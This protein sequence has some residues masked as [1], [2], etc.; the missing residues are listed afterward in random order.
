MASSRY[1]T[2]SIMLHWLT[3]IV[4]AL[5]YALIELHHYFPKHTFWHDALKHWHSQLGLVV[6]IIT[7]VRLGV[8]W[9]STYS[10]SS[11]S[12][13]L[14]IFAADWQRQ[15][16]QWMHRL[17]YG[18]LMLLP[19]LGWLML[20]AKGKPIDLFGWELPVLMMPDLVLG[21]EIESWHKTLANLG[22]GLIALHALA[23][24]YHHYIIK[25][26]VLTSMLPWRVRLPTNGLDSDHS[27]IN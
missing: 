17:L 22:Y 5:V 13:T 25:D 15:L 18:F 16:A 26:Q 12:S 14:A 2:L 21:K 8:V 3:V 27:S 19:L 4:I 10:V 9:G 6:L 20:S 23:A 1:G 11:S 7:V 24:L